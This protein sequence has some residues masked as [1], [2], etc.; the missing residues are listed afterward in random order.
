M[1]NDEEN[2]GVRIDPTFNLGSYSFGKR[3]EELEPRVLG[4]T[5]AEPSSEQYLEG[6]REQKYEELARLLGFDRYIDFRKEKEQRKFFKEIKDPFVMLCLKKYGGRDDILPF[7][8]PYQVTDLIQEVGKSILIMK[9]PVMSRVPSSRVSQGEIMI[10][11]LLADISGLKEGDNVYYHGLMMDE[12]GLYD[13][14]PESYIEKVVKIDKIDEN[15]IYEMRKNGLPYKL[16]LAEMNPNDLMLAH[17]LKEEPTQ[18]ETELYM[19]TLIQKKEPKPDETVAEIEKP[20]PQQDLL[21]Q[22]PEV[23]E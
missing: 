10:T 3:L 15:A 8:E 4:E 6:F 20:E 16:F 1:P 7:F 13:D 9:R 18:K 2:Q 11:D 23:Q 14:I 21:S 5:E 12:F 22:F 17:R 19:Y